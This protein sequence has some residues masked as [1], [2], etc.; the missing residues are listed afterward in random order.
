MIKLL[1]NEKTDHLVNTA[2]SI[3]GLATTISTVSIMFIIFSLEY[4]LMRLLIVSV[5]A[6][7]IPININK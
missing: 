6:W 7:L 3:V 4:E 2:I 5:L 1:P